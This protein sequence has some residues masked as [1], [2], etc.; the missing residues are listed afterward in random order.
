[1][2]I[3]HL[4]NKYQKPLLKLVNNR[5]G[6]KFLG[7]EAKE[8]IVGLTP[9]AY[10]VRKK[11]GVYKAT[12]RCYPLFAKKLY[13]ALASVNILENLKKEKD[14]RTYA[15]LGQYRGLLNYC[16]LFEQPRL[17][18]QIFLDSATFFV[19]AADGRI[20]SHLGSWDASHDA[21]SGHSSAEDSCYVG[22]Q[23]LADHW[24]S[25]GFF[26]ANL[27][28]I[29]GS[30]ISAVDFKLYITG[31]QDDKGGTYAAAVKTFQASFTS[32]TGSDFEDCGYDSGH[33]EGGRAKYSPT[34]KGSA[35]KAFTS[36]SLNAY[37]TFSLN[38]TGLAW[39]SPAPSYTPIGL[40]EGYDISDTNPVLNNEQAIVLTISTSSTAG[41]SQDPKYD[42]T[43]IPYISPAGN[44]LM[45]G[46]GLAV[47]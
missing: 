30:T 17:F 1:M 18:P 47:G 25:R 8:K 6:R 31:K 4:F 40:R 42:I 11:R 32:L 43:Y 28:S 37:N 19:T 44:I 24:L 14:Y 35:N 10:I 15:N 13:Y 9:N 39:F 45:F 29:A 22:L 38:A 5:F 20:Y 33:E 2:K 34:V 41:T 27:S 36:I 26:P 46:G 3:R 21:A 12:F 23:R 7:I 16:G